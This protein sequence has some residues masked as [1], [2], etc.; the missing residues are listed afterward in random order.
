MKATARPKWE[1]GRPRAGTGEA[2]MNAT[3]GRHTPPATNTRGRPRSQPHTRAQRRTAASLQGGQQQREKEREGC[4]CVCGEGEG[5]REGGRER[6]RERAAA[7]GTLALAVRCVLHRQSTSSRPPASFA[8]SRSTQPKLVP[9]LPHA[10]HV[11]VSAAACPC[12]HTPQG[13]LCSPRAAPHNPLQSR[14]APPT[15][16]NP[17]ECEP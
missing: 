8:Q 4:V 17:L 15:P 2:C 9:G 6:E 12:A 3:R 7:A 11:V 5:G 16:L 1:D 13:T 10:A 14:P